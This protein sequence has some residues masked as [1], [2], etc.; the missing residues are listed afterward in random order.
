MG[1]SSDGPSNPQYPKPDLSRAGRDARAQRIS[2]FLGIRA[3]RPPGDLH[4]H[5]GEFN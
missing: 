3:I 4:T 5:C 1:F 2:V